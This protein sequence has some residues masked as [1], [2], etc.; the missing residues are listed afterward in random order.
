MLLL[1]LNADLIVELLYGS[2]WV[3]SSK[4]LTWLAIAGVLWPIHSVNVNFILARGASKYFFRIELAKQ[5]LLLCSLSAAFL[6]G[7]TALAIATSLASCVSVFLN[8]KFAGRSVGFGAWAQLRTVFP[9][10]C[11]AAVSVSLSSR[12]VRHFSFAG[13]FVLEL[14]ALTLT[15]AVSYMVLSWVI[16][17]DSFQ[18]VLRQL[19]YYESGARNFPHLSIRRSSLLYRPLHAIRE[20]FGRG[21]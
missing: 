9:T 12:F 13:S 1:G 6:G 4:P 18:I 20:M 11:V 8:C 17:L 10:L 2:N 21:K 7:L 16:R 15:C 5:A 19:P 14:M 3:A